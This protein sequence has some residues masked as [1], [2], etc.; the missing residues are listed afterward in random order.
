MVARWVVGVVLLAAGPASANPASFSFTGSNPGFVGVTR[1]G[2]EV[3]DAAADVTGARD[4]VGGA[5]APVIY[6]ASDANHVYFRIRVNSDALTTPTN[7]TTYAWGCALD[8]NGIAQNY[9][10]LVFV[11]GITVPDSVSFYTNTV[12]TI[13][14]SAND[15]PD[16]P[17]KSI[18]SDPLVSNVRHA[19]Q[20]TAPSMFSAT[21]DYFVDWVVDTTTFATYGVDITKPVRLYCGSSTTG[22]T[23]N[24]DCAGSSISSCSLSTTFS[25]AVT[26]H[27]GGAGVCGDSIVSAGEACDDGD[28]ANGDGCNA[29]CRREN[30]AACTQ[31]AQCASEFCNPAGSTC[32]CRVDGDCAAGQL[33][34]AGN[35]CIAGGCGNGIIERTESCEDGN[36]VGGDGCSANCLFELGLPCTSSDQCESV[37][38]G[39][40]GVCVC[41]EHSDCAMTGAVCRDASCVLPA[42]GDGFVDPGEECDD[43]NSSSSDVCSNTC[44]QQPPGDG[45]GCSAGQRSSL[46]LVLVVAFGFAVRRRHHGAARL[47]RRRRHH[48]AIANN[49]TQ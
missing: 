13:S 42:C 44:Q 14:N 4:I 23:I 47:R 15:A 37:S 38:C 33:C 27:S 6:V 17:V 36:A 16:Q 1:N 39:P 18:V 3:S 35:A 11:D 45:E 32:A 41:N 8:T 49:T 9:E 12:T 29:S 22:V 34:T 26:F 30:G 10:A 20:V 40:N 46:W 2:I 28:V 21:T 25:D 31:S 19:Q 5:G 7:L 43:G 48:A 24:S